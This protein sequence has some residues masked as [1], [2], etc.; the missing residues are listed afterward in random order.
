MCK[1]TAFA[2]PISAGSIINAIAGF[3]SMMMVARLGKEELAA[4]ALA[5]STYMTI[6]TVAATILYSVGILI[7]HHRSQ[8][9]TPA[10][11][12]LIVKNGFWLALFL[13]IPTGLG[14]W[15]GDTLLLFFKQDPQLVTLTSG[16][17]HFAALNMFPLLGG[18]VL[19]QFYA[20][21]GKPR[22]TLIIAL[23]SLPLTMVS[24]YGLILG[25]FGLPKLRLSGMTC[26]SLIVQSF[27][28]LVVLIMM[29]LRKSIQSYQ[30][31]NK[32]FLPNGLICKSIFTLGMPIGIQFGIEFIAMTMAT[33]LMGYFGVTALAAAQIVSQYYMPIIIL[34]IGLTQALSL[35]ISD[36]YGKGDDRLIKEYLRA[37]I[38]LLIIYWAFIG[39]IFLG[40]PKE[41]IRLYMSEKTADIRLE[42]LVIIFFAISAFLLFIDGFRH[43][44]SGALR[45]LHDSRGPMQ[46]GIAAMWF[47]SLPVSYLIGFTFQG[48]PI[49]LRI[50]FLSGFIFAGIFLFLRM[51]KKLYLIKQAKI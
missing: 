45:G 20:G 31:F 5:I 29:Y 1:V 10:E 50:G 47:V 6:M 19:A 41:L 34:L 13:A 21:I 38:V 8:Y 4:G 42:H 46:I 12:G 37:S 18:T 36:A 22:F 35:L 30:L 32:P 51:H 25:H 16:Y 39:S 44:L 2:L 43:L 33:Y 40:I 17:F 49:G 23:I 14:L 15:Y 11:I 48:G 9:K 3:I 27:I 24:A 26:A 28:M 7:S